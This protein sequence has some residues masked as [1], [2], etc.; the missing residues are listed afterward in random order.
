[1]MNELWLTEIRINPRHHAAGRDL[2]S[3]TQL[4]RTVMSMFPDTAADRPRQSLGVLHRL[5][6]TPTGPVLLVQSV[7]RPNVDVIPDDYGMT[8]AVSLLPLVERLQLGTPV[9]YRILVN[10]TKKL[11]TGDR[12]GKRVALGAE[13]AREWWPQRA[14]DAG[15]SLV[16]ECTMVGDTLVG[17]EGDDGRITLRPWR[18]DGVATVGDPSATMKALE[19]GIGRGRAYGC[20]MLSLSLLPASQGI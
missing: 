1:M 18:I 6:S 13:A 12:K 10:A 7:P 8:R 20:G 11:G 17:R 9:R 2:R 15:L 4:H 16:G 3:I 14:E 19:L 5:D